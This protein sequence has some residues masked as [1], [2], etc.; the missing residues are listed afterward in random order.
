MATSFANR[1]QSI[2]LLFIISAFI[3]IYQA[4]NL[5][6]L[7][8][9][10]A[11]EAD[12]TA[13]DTYT[14]YPSRGLIY[15]RNHTL[16]INNNPVYD[17][18]VT[19][20][21]V[22][23]DMDKEKF[24]E[25]LGIDTLE[26]NTR[27]NKNWNDARYSR[28]SPF[29]FLSTVSAVTYARF[30]ESLY[31]FPGFYV[32]TRNVRAYPWPNA[33]HVLG[34]IREVSQQELD[35][36]EEINEGNNYK[37]GDYIGGTGLE[38]E[39]EEQLRGQKGARY[40]LKDNL[41]RVVGS[42]KDGELDRPPVSGVDMTSSLDIR[43]QAYAEELM[44]GK[45]GAVVAIEPKTGEILSMVSMP[46]YNPNDLTINRS[47][48]EA[49]RRLSTDSLKPFFN[50]AVMA[51]YPPGSIFKPVI[52]LVGLQKGYLFPNTYHY[53]PGYYSYNSFIWGCRNHP[54]PIGVGTAVQFSCNT[55]FFQTFRDIIDK[56]ESFYK[57]EVGLD[58]LVSYLY[59]FGFGNELGIDF[60]GEQEGN[61]PTSE[62][63]N[64]LYPKDQGG[65]KSPTILSLGIGQGE[66]QL[67]TMQM[68]NL[69]AV[70]ANRGYYKTPHLVKGF[71][72]PEIQIP[73]KYRVNNYS[74]IDPEH[75]QPVV[76]GMISVVNAGTGRIA[77]IPD[78]TVAGKTGTVENP[79]GDDHSTFIAFA[80]ADDPQIAIAVYVENAGGGGRF[81]APIA[82]LLIEKYLTGEIHP[83]RNWVEKRMLETKLTENP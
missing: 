16:L 24:C 6:V 20:N 43:L 34:F 72:D 54:A 3:L 1:Q 41:G 60:P 17:I 44:D 15:D 78:V 4:L 53:C 74:G 58:T 55:Y 73:E 59:R 70:L 28:S 10:Y 2:R 36:Q 57:P 29:I 69:A 27:L 26:F 32:Q 76:D 45:I 67:T 79:H 63:Y 77:F 7:D 46:T 19:Y 83:S 22:D 18:L 47:R 50:R 31:E 62:Y 30:Q 48:G 66:I 5:Q 39:Y 38:K 9:S 81:A 49:V 14:L 21:Q 35:T 64:R 40:V 71:S 80:P 33:A 56:E 61:I 65:W 13:S 52:G 37:P 75:F 42:Y 12:A 23:P 51:K 11:A 68:A 25:L 8:E 82:S